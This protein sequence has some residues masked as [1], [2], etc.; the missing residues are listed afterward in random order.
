MPPALAGILG[1][2]LL[3][4]RWT[5]RALADPE[6]HVAALSRPQR[7]VETA[8]A[9]LGD[10]LAVGSGRLDEEVVNAHALLEGLA[11]RLAQE[12]ERL[13]GLADESVRRS[14]TGS[15]ALRSQAEALAATASRIAGRLDEVRATTGSHAA[16]ALLQ[17]K[18]AAENARRRLV[19]VAESFDAVGKRAAAAAEG[20]VAAFALAR[21]AFAGETRRNGE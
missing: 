2:W 4:R 17:A 11:D 14:A 9:T 7:A 20:A 3:T 1:W 18:Q 6:R 15:E 19:A 12:A 13:A 21:E 16:A 8:L 5:D 10:R